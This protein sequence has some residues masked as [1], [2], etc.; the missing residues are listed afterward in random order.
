MP[1]VE[2]LN[3]ANVSEHLIKNLYDFVSPE[4]QQKAGRCKKSCDRIRCIVGEALIRH[5]LICSCKMNNNNIFFERDYWHKPRLITS[6]KL[7]LN[8]THSGAWVICA[9]DN[10]EI[11]ADVETVKSIPIEAMLELFHPDEISI[12]S[13]DKS[14]FFYTSFWTVK[15]SYMKY[16]GM[17]FKLPMDSFCI[18]KKNGLYVECSEPDVRFYQRKM[19][20][21]SILTVCTKSKMPIKFQSVDI[22]EILEMFEM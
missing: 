6:R 22:F 15:E 1:Y 14:D 11:G 2:Y 7:L 18:T 5:Y 12:L 8:L 17:G 9:W 20:K 4:R 3:V 19:D 10:Q 16:R 13:D 21:E